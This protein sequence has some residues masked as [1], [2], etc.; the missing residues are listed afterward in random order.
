MS[1]GTSTGLTSFIPHR[2][3]FVSSGKQF[4]VKDFNIL[5]FEVQHDAKEPLGY[6][7]Q[8]IPTGEKLLFLTD[9]YYSK[10]GR[11]SCRERV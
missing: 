7:I 6:L 10:I 5:P 4:K 2:L 9:S 11:A 8:Y 3:I 1:S